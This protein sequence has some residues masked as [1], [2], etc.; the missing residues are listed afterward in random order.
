MQAE[1]TT[2]SYDFWV[3]AASMTTLVMVSLMIAA[4]AWAWIASGSA[5]M[6]GSLTDSLLDVSA[7]LVNFFVLSYAL[8]PADDDHRFGHGKAEALAGL[9]QAAFIAGSGCLLA[10][11]AIERFFNPV[12][13]THSLLGVWVSVFAIVCT[14][15]VVFVQFQ[16]I[17]RTESVALKADSLHYKGDLMLNIAVMVA[18]ALAYYGVSGAD[19]FF[20]LFVAAYLLFNAWQIAMESSSHLMDKELP[21]HEKEHI[22]AVACAHEAVHGVHALRT[23][24]GGKVRFVEFHLELDDHITLVQAH[25]I[26]DEVEAMVKEA[27][28]LSKHPEF[29][30]EVDVL[31]HQDPVSA[32]RKA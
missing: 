9:G 7:T 22:V 6:L 20:A 24:Q 31:I 21:E 29:G 5:A 27:F 26:A 2:R 28:S 12:A 32:T 19:P 4:K 3:K 25:A 10:F 23:R 17:K 30:G 13:I 1:K 16:A 11:H 15:I 8:K 18:L 14:L